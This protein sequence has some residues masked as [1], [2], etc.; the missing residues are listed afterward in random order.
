MSP[1]FGFQIWCQVGGGGTPFSKLSYDVY[2]FS[3]IRFEIYHFSYR[4]SHGF[5]KKHKFFI[6]LKNLFCRSNSEH[7]IRILLILLCETLHEILFLQNRGFRSNHFARKDR[8]Q[9]AWCIV[10]I[11]V[12]D[13]RSIKSVLQRSSY[14]VGI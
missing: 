3:S 5:L 10:Y 8:A 13:G 1:T 6:N 14:F 4:W 7:T 2:E 11:Y 9:S 12:W